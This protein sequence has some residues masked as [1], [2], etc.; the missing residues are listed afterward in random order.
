MQV[1]IT[2]CVQE[3]GIS[4][5]L[6]FISETTRVRWMD[7]RRCRSVSA[8]TNHSGDFVL[9][10]VQFG[11]DCVCFLRHECTRVFLIDCASL[12]ALNGVSFV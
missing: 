2:I 3:V 11:L 4:R 8:R 1:Y 7:A 12:F 5:Y 9:H 10:A 6:N